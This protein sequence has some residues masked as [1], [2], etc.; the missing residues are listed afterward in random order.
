MSETETKLRA[1]AMGAIGWSVAQNWGGRI[2]TF[3]LFLVLARLLTPLEF[4]LASAALIVLTIIG[5]VAEF[6]YGDALVQRRDYIDAD[7]NLPFVISLGLALA[8]AV[9]TVMGA[10]S[11]EGWLGVTGLSPI[12]AVVA[13]I[14][15]LTTI[16]LFQEIAYRRAIQYKRL[17]LRVFIAS[18]IAG[19]VAVAAGYLGY[20]VWSLVIQSYVAVI[21]G[22]VWLWWRPVWKPSA[23]LRVKSFWELTAFGLPVVASRLLDMGALR[24]FE[25]KMIGQFGLALFGFYAVG[26]RLYQTLNQMLFS[27]LNDVSMSILS[28]VSHDVERTG[29]IYL[30]TITIAS[31]TFAPIYVVVASVI[32]EVSS[33]LFGAKWSGVEQYALPLLLLGAVQS[34]QFLNGPYLSSLG[35]PGRVFV[36]G[37]LRSIAL[38]GLLLF[39]PIKDI[40]ELLHIFVLTQLVGTPFSFWVT[41]RELKLSVF[42]VVGSVL[43]GS[44]ACLLGYLAVSYLRP[45]IATQIDNAFLLGVALGAAFAGIF[46]VTASLLGFAQLRDAIGFLLRR[47]LPKT[48]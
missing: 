44:V 2:F 42:E 32:S 22:I 17:A 7:A 35:R 13:P 41:A 40:I 9:A 23:V 11:I 20:G 27:A 8:L 14:A 24:F 38:I 10:S 36:V 4:G 1:S 26:S 46:L 47:Q 6:G 25:A 21:I 3:L 12:I 37:S 33:V 45:I 34:V 19:C 16:S 18:V 31:L 28:R 39:Y 43:P 15:P 48:A 29:N 5:Q 30:R